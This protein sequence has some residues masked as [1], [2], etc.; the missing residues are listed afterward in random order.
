MVAVNGGHY[1]TIVV[2]LA[3]LAEPILTTLFQWGEFGKEA[4]MDASEILLIASA[5][6]PFYAISTFLVKVFHSKKK[7]NLPLQAAVISL[8]ANLFF[9]LFLIGEYQV[10]GLAWANVLAAMMQTLYLVF[11]L[12]EI[13]FKTLLAKQPLHLFQF[14][15]RRQ[16]WLWLSGLCDK[17]S[18]FQVKNRKFVVSISDNSRSDHIW[19]RPSGFQ[20][21]ESNK[22]AKDYFPLVCGGYEIIDK[23]V[24]FKNLQL[25]MNQSSDKLRGFTLM[26]LMAVLLSS[27]FFSGSFLRGPYLFS[28]QEDKKANAGVETIAL[29]LKQFHSEHGIILLPRSLR[30]KSNAEKFY[31][32]L[33]RVGWILPE[34]KLKKISEENHFCHP[35]AMLL[36]S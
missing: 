9:S 1:D 16:A 12:E 14:C 7:M 6:L 29:A 31:L 19:N 15:F 30:R 27:E 4:V 10:H 35:I 11:R 22:I 36:D 21:S 8:S 2:G 26:E 5:G 17:I 20:V 3:I 25:S 34:T 18:L 23:A 33:C 32:C 13:S 24:G 28:A